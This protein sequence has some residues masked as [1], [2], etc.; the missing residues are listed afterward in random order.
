MSSP[1]HNPTK[2]QTL[3][4][5]LGTPWDR[6]TK[7]WDKMGGTFSVPYTVETHKFGFESLS[8]IPR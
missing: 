4:H 8:V 5:I 3:R 1:F 2:L 6:T 7:I